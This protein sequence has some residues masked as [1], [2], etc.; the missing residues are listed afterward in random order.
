MTMI[1][2]VGLL[3]ACIATAT[4]AQAPAK[5]NGAMRLEA[6]HREAS[7][8]MFTVDW[9]APSGIEGF[10]T[11]FPDGLFVSTVKLKDGSQVHNVGSYR[12]AGDSWCQTPRAPNSKETCSLG[13]RTGE[14]AYEA[15]NAD[16]TFAVHW[17]F[18]LKK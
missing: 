18:R 8:Q 2:W 1:A 17:S 6:D 11:Y 7:R 10:T 3:S 15:W 12:I 5:P 13:Y 14:N 9:R 16:G 4:L